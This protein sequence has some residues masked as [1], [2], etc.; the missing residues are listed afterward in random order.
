MARTIA[1]LLDA[2]ELETYIYI[3]NDMF[4][5][6]ETDEDEEEV[7]DE[8]KDAI[9]AAVVEGTKD[10]RLEYLLYN[11][12]DTWVGEQFSDMMYECIDHYV[13]QEIRERI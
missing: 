8:R 6:F 13:E 5:W 3:N 9:I 10:G 11:L 2:D 7:S 1:S 4:D 12:F